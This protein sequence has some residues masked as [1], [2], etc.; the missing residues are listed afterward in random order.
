[1]ISSNATRRVAYGTI[2]RMSSMFIVSVILITFYNL[3]G[4]LI[5][6]SA[7]STGVIMEALASRLMSGKFVKNVKQ[8]FEM[9]FLII[10]PTRDSKIL[11]SSRTH[12]FHI[13]CIHPW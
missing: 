9:K 8:K 7:L 1:M 10:Y 3:D 5:G 13:T 12:F 4:V 6:A 11:L 2:I